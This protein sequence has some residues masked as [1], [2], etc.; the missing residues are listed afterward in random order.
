VRILGIDLL[1]R[2]ESEVGHADLLALIDEGCAFQ[3]H[4][5][6]RDRFGG[7]RRFVPEDRG[8]PR[9][10]MVLHVE[11]VPAV[12]SQ[13][14]LPTRKHLFEAQQIEP[15]RA[16]LSFAHVVFQLEDH[17]QI[18]VLFGPV[19]GFFAGNAARFPDRHDRVGIKN[20]LQLLHIDFDSRDI[21]EGSPGV[22]ADFEIPR[23]FLD[24][25]DRIQ[26]EAVDPQIQPPAD[27]PAD[28][29]PHLRVFPVQIRL[30]R[31]KDMEV[32]L[33]RIFIV[34]PGRAAEETLPS[35]RHFIFGGVRP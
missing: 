13:V 19:H 5:H 32:G 11:G 18:A 21:H 30:F 27:H 20:F 28:F 3:Q 16:R 12:R 29:F 24:M 2:L 15:F 4:V 6:R 26:P 31:R 25:A 23:F 9:I 35:I 33:A 34:R 7:F 22:V 17:V 10:I 1:H 8:D 14:L